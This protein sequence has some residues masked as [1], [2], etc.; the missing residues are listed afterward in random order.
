M[1][2]KG[3]G[4]FIRGPISLYQLNEFIKCGVNA[5]RIFAFIR[6]KEGKLYSKGLLPKDTHTF[7]KIDNKEAEQ[8][9]GLHRSHKWRSLRILE[10]RKLIKLNVRGKGRAPEAKILLPILH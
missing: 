3:A 6:H 10:E 1:I 7:I 8:I 5:V 4:K 9:V 2:M